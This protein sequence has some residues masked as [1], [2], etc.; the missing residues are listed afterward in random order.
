MN[1]RARVSG[2]RRRRN[3]C[4]RLTRAWRSYLGEILGRRASRS[5]PGYSISRFQR[6]DTPS[7]W[8][9]GP[10]RVFPISRSQHESDKSKSPWAETLRDY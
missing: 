2:D 1:L 6:E 4:R 9:N 5:A 7:G 8:F 10:A 3:L